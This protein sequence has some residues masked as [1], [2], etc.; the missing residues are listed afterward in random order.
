MDAEKLIHLVQQYEYLY[1]AH[2]YDYLD[3]DKRK[4]AWAQIGIE[5]NTTGERS[6]YLFH[7]LK[8]FI[9]RSEC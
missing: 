2:R 7:N 4:N 6:L 8:I 1:A 9:E 5:M 3:R